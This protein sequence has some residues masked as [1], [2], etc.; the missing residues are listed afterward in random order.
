MYGGQL[1][2]VG[3]F[4]RTTGSYIDGN[5]NTSTILS[6]GLAPG[7]DQAPSIPAV[8]QGDCIHNPSPA[9][10]TVSHN[11]DDYA[12]NRPTKVSPDYCQ[13]G[14]MRRAILS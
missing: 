11:Q 2:I 7:D 9:D 6:L 4:Q 12:L 10:Q 1:Y 13:H 14:Y 3:I 8:Q 5:E